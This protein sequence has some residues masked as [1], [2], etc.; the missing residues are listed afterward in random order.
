[1][2][3]YITY[4]LIIIALLVIVI[5]FYFKSKNKKENISPS[6]NKQSNNAMDV[7]T[8]EIKPNDDI[9]QALNGNS[10]ISVI[11][12]KTDIQYNALQNEISGLSFSDNSKSTPEVIDSSY[13]SV[14]ISNTGELPL[15]FGSQ[16]QGTTIE[17]PENN[18]FNQF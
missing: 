11:E 18:N 1:M 12:Q 10:Q 7:K 14:I 3:K 8:P 16:N 13:N 17:L 5:Y 15:D 6:E 4:I 9:N 2:K